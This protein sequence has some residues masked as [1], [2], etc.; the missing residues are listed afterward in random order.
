MFLFLSLFV[1]SS[2][3]AQ[4][5]SAGYRGAE[6]F[7]MTG[8]HLRN[9]SSLNKDLD[10]YDLP[11]LNG[12]LIGTGI[13]GGIFMKNF[14]IGGQGM[15]QFSSGTSNDFYEAD[16]F[17]G[18][19]M[20]QG[21]YVLANLPSVSFYPTLGIGGGGTSIRLEEG[22]SYDDI[23]LEFLADSDIHT[24]YMLLDIGVNG[25]FYFGP[26]GRKKFLIGLSAGYQ[27]SPVSKAWKYRDRELS[28]FTKFDLD[29]FYAKIKLGLFFSGND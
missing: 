17:E 29:G 20:L 22:S 21:G 11:Q 18:Y 6:F 15:I 19:G 12:S 23:D 16:L 26:G 1:L 7:A 24:S 28:D 13:G 3:V 25:D 4:S 8:L 9:T 2:N 14:F 5:S 27:Y 10:H